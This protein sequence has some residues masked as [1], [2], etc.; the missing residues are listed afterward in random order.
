MNAV[1]ILDGKL[2]AQQM[3]AEIKAEL[4]QFVTK[5]FRL[6]HLVVIL[7]GNDGASQAYVKNKQLACEKAGILSTKYHLPNDTSQEELLS[8]IAKLNADEGVD[9]ILVQLPLPKQISENAVIEAISPEKDVDG[10]HPI[11]IGRMAKNLPAPLPATPAGILALLAHYEIVTEGKHCVVIG[12][13]NIVG[14]PVSILMARANYPGNATVTLCHSKTQNLKFFT[15]NA[16]ILIVAAGKKHFI[17]AEFIKPG[18]IV[19]DVGIH[20]TVDEHGKNKLTG[21]VDFESAKEVC[22]AITPVPGGIGPM[23]IAQLLKNTIWVWKQHLN[24]S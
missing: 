11:N 14:S 18:A 1:Q 13:S 9:G 24:I 15:Q 16:D 20:S 3:N 4:D 7:V 8:K 23:T 2:V 12:R 10:F 5:G 19:I 6:P 17:N 21:D 22:S